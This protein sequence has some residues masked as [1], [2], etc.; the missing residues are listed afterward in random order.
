MLNVTQL[1]KTYISG[2]KVEGVKNIT[3]SV[4]EGEIV[5]ILGASGSGKSTLLR[6][7]AGLIS[8]D[9]GEIQYGIDS[10]EYTYVAQDYTLWPHLNVLEN[11]ILAPSLKKEANTLAIKKEAKNLLKRFGL[12]DYVYSYPHELS[13]GQKQRVALLRAIISKPKVLLLDEVTSALDP[14]LTKSVLDL[15]R[16]LAKDGY[17]ML[18]VTHHMSFALSVADRILF[19]KRGELLAD[20]TMTEFFMNQKNKEIKD[21]IIDIAKK[22]EYIE[23]FKGLEQFQAY[24]LSLMKRL[25][26]DITI[27]IAGG[28]SDRWYGLMGDLLSK[29]TEIRIKKRITWKM[30]MYEVGES[31]NKFVS[32]NPTYNDFR[33]MPRQL[34]NPANYNVFGDT[35]ITQIFE[36]EPTIIQIKNQN[37]ADAYKRFFEELWSLAK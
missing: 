31:D 22:D 21:F 20:E 34:Q 16:T 7:L 19:L 23:V 8:P 3:F 24:H 26:E 36:G 2:D 11:L 14:N 5:C 32:D 28:V 29:Y 12:F 18:I 35:V 9:K 27:H 15:I 10:S 30:V 1:T 37:I 13:G 17:T 6:T 4:K 25:P 33:A